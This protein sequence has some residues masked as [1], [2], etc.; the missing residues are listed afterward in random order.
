MTG[1]HTCLPAVG[2]PPPGAATSRSNA[3]R[4]KGLQ[5]RKKPCRVAINF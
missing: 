4:K 2:E 1:F 5:G 3:G